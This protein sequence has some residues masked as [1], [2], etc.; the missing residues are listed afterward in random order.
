M[1]KFKIFVIVLFIFISS[2]YGNFSFEKGFEFYRVAVAESETESDLEQELENE[3][4]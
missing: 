4:S 2:F 1:K 3:I